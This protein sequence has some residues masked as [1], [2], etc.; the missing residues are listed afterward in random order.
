MN[1]D[2]GTTAR[3]LDYK[4][5]VDKWLNEHIPVLSTEQENQAL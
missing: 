1:L 2:I 3:I 4:I 5:Y